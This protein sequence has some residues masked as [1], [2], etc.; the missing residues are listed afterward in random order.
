[1]SR[2]DVLHGG[3]GR[4]HAQ[5][6]RAK[7][8]M[9]SGVIM[10]DPLA[11]RHPRILVRPPTRRTGVGAGQAGDPR[12]LVPQGRGVRRR[13]PR[14]LR[15]RGRGRT[16]RRVSAN[17]ARR[18]AAAWR[19]SCCS[20]SSR[21][22]SFADTPKCLP[23]TRA[24]LA[25][26]EDA[27]ARGFDRSLAPERALVPVHAVRARRTTPRRTARW[28]CSSSSPRRPGCRTPLE[29]AQRHRDVIRRFGRYPH[30]NA[31]LGR[32]STAEELAFLREPGS[33][34]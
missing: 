30:R 14:A 27:L 26:A 10:L 32:E 11:A 4:R 5:A 3:P 29:W 21:A 22:T 23:A 7:G 9:I 19:A 1:M 34:F 17:G 2:R 25:M 33:R 20:I 31:L 12:R 24:R 18:R 13:D 16:R 28:R 6:R 15:R 8:R